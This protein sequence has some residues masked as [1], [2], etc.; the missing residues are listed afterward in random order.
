MGILTENIAA[1]SFPPGV[2]DEALWRAA[3][4]QA[5][6]RSCDIIQETAGV[7][8]GDEG[9][10][11][12][13][14]NAARRMDFLAAQGHLSRPG[15]H[16]YAASAEL[17]PPEGLPPLA[18]IFISDVRLRRGSAGVSSSGATEISAGPAL[19]PEEKT[20]A[21]IAGQVRAAEAMAGA[22][23]EPP[24]PF[25]A[26]AGWCGLTGDEGEM[27]MR[28]HLPGKVLLLDGGRV[29]FRFKNGDV[30]S[31]TLASVKCPV[32]DKGFRW[33]KADDW[34]GGKRLWS[35]SPPPRSPRWVLSVEGETSAIAAAFGLSHRSDW[36]VV[37]TTGAG[38]FPEPA[39]EPGATLRRIMRSTGAAAVA[40][41]DD[42]LAGNRWLEGAAATLEGFPLGRVKDAPGD[43]RSVWLRMLESGL[44]AAA[45]EFAEM[46]DAAAAGAVVAVKPP[47]GDAP[48]EPGSAEG[49]G[50]GLPSSVPPAWTPTPNGRREAQPRGA[51]RR[52]LTGK[53]SVTDSL[54][55]AG[56]GAGRGRGRGNLSCFNKEGHRAG[57]RN[58]SLSVTGQGAEE[59][60]KCFGC[61]EAGDIFTAY[62]LG[63]HGGDG[64]AAARHIYEQIRREGGG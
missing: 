39:S 6:R 32:E 62:A 14:L 51:V 45:G 57:D 38:M 47:P 23:G 21:I 35:P 19:S 12:A 44:D 37:A 16:L 63:H 10:P 55:R 36:W 13:A 30:H 17:P 2:T 28:H 46:C 34:A 20:A 50:V 8:P 4:G 26:L 48:E 15:L 24:E 58:P 64:K 18:D 49:D 1:S 43:P 7:R 41:P 9:W 61:G 3:S 33:H 60:F 59:H 11:D 27:W 25:R 42:D 22:A 54:M 53:H 52:W 29:G 56:A 5:G 40:W 31:R